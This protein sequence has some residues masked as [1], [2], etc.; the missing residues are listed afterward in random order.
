[1]NLFEQQLCK[2]RRY[3]YFHFADGE[4]KG[5]DLVSKVDTIRTWFFL[6]S[7]AFYHIPNVQNTIFI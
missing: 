1:M 2:V 4:L 5:M 3:Y 7:L 6:E